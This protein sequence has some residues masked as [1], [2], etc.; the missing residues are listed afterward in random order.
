MENNISNSDINAY[1]MF[2]KVTV[3]P[4]SY[5]TIQSA[6]EAIEGFMVPGQEEYLFNKV[7][8]LP[9]DA[10]IVEIGSYKGRSTVAMSYACIGTNRKIY[11]LDTWD[12]NDTDFSD[13]NFFDIWQENIEKNGL[14]QYVVP[15]RGYSHQILSQW[16]EL[17]G[18]KAIDFIFI[19]GSHQFLDVLK[20][21]EQSLPLVKDG[22]WIAFHDVVPT[23][24]GPERVWHNIAKHCLLNHE[25][26]S[27]LACGQKNST[28]FSSTSSPELPIHFFTI[29]LNGEPFIEYHIEV[30]KQLPYK[31]HWHIVEGVAD[32]KHDTAWSLLHG[33]R[34]TDEIHS[35][36]RSNDGTAEYLDELAQLYPENVT[37]YRKPEGIFWEGKREMV[38]APLPNIRE[39]CLLWQ[40]DVDEL[41]TGEQLCTARYMF[42]NNPEKTAA[43]YW[44]WYFVGE[45][46]VISTRNCYAQNP[47]QEWL[48]TWRFKPGHV[49]VRHEPPILAEPLP[50]GDLRN[51][52]EFN[53]FRHE[54]TENLGLVF[55]H[56]AYVIPEQ[57]RFKEQYYGY[58]NALSQWTALQQQTKFPALLRQYLG[59]VQDGTTVDTAESCGVVPI[60]QKESNGTRWRFV[61]PDGLQS[62]T[63]TTQTQSPRILI[64][65]VFFQLY[66][67]G[68]ARV[69]NSL[70]EEWAKNGFSQHIIILDRA[71]TA[72]K[73]VGIRYLTIPAY[74]YGTADADRQMLQQVCDE[75]GADLFISTYYTTPLSTPSVFM[76]YDMIPEVLEANLNEPMWRVKHHGIR[77]ASAY[78]AISENTAQDLVKFFPNI[79]LGS[80]S[81]AHC[82]VKSSFSPASKE[83][84]SNFKNKYGISKP[85]FISVGGGSDYKNTEL[86]FQAFAQLSS[87]QGFEV[88]CTGSSVLLELEFRAYTAG[89]VVHKLNLNDEELRVAYSGAIALVYP[90]LYEGF[91]LPVLEAM[92]CG[93]PVITCPNAS[94]PEVAGEA[95]LYVNDKD[96]EGFAQALCEVQKPKVRN[97]L[98]RGGLE[99]AK[100]FS[101][102]KMAKIV[103]SVLMKT[104]I[105]I[106][107]E[108]GKESEGYNLQE[109]IKKLLVAMRDQPAYQL[110]LPSSLSQIPEPFLNE[111]IS[112]LFKNP[113][114][115]QEVGEVEKYYQH[116]QRWVDELHTNIVGQLDVE[117]WR[118]VAITFTYSANF[119]LYFT[120]ANLKEIYVK[121][122]T[123]I[124]QTLRSK[125]HQ[126]D[127]S[128]PEKLQDT[129]KIRLGILATNF[130]PQAEI[131][132]TLPVYKSLN[133]DLFEIIIYFV[134]ATG[135]RFERYCLGCAD[136]AV[137]LPQDLESQVQTIRDG[138]LDILF[139]ATNVTAQTNRIAE[140]A[141]HR[142]ARVQ[143]VGMN[144]PVSTGMRHVD[145]YISSKLTEAGSNPQQHYS[146]TLVTLD[147]PA[148]CF[149]FA[150]EEQLLTTINVNRE[151]LNIAQ[152]AVIYISGANFYKIIPEVEETWAK[153]LARVPNSVL[154]LYPFNPNW[155]PI[156]PVTAFEERILATLARHGVG[157]DRLILLDAV[158]NRADVKERLKVADIYLDSYPYA[159]MTSLIDPLE[160]GVPTVVMS[161]DYARSNMGA[162][163]LRELEMFDLIVDSEEAYVELAVALGTNPELRFQKSNLLNQKMQ[164][165]PRFLDSRSYSARIGLVF[166]EIFAKYQGNILKENLRLSALNLIIF[167]DWGQPEE[168]LLQELVSVLRAIAT[169]P[170]KS[171][172][173]LL[174]DSSNVSDDDANL[175]LSSVAMN[176]LMEEDLD[177]SEGPEISLVGQLSKLQWQALM[178]HL[179]GRIVL[180]QE[181]TE[182]STPTGFEKIPSY[183]LES[184]TN[185]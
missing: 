55:Q 101:W 21:Y 6:V 54:E 102:S 70:L 171:K 58:T 33:G 141:V 42:I 158:P 68:I 20:D 146:E 87:K 49:W 40:V 107:D 24:P 4:V 12:G 85:Y 170:D 84:I 43:F 167:P 124:E 177:V 99:Q 3:Q 25:Y 67:T 62:R 28:A 154:V 81:V 9:N 108:N 147:V 155:A 152:S 32:L 98:I 127:Y 129:S 35:K 111:Y 123:I 89:T 13:R 7:K 56:F 75:E 115:F 82:G 19:D 69:W 16:E 29:V 38:N 17:T 163:L 157:K 161:G 37:V 66:R 178:S 5:T 57:L 104:A 122:A 92:A 71:G 156:Y 2:K 11:C 168:L 172:M 134:N 110:S 135:H 46:L 50:N 151:I 15:L 41:W 128:F 182:V 77:H 175:I 120:K 130:H 121:R 113:P 83:E 22:G 140:L 93:C 36:G 1:G 14:S 91:G 144:S 52:A 23:W 185:M 165:T 72:P 162:S 116:I 80:V 79:A 142:L 114:L 180:K 183:L 97:S 95:A 47:A 96:V 184:F 48:R 88:I 86:F 31:W 117:V 169:H 18:D 106:T 145:Y 118:E 34:I 181:N 74:N 109:S 131:F 45:N 10:V 112:L 125:G 159:G 63:L 103:S 179:Q 174:V 78:I 160:V 30:F 173:T 59:W 61:E 132:A 73:I 136:T 133:R 44:C 166:Q 153:I 64:D 137:R 143:V 100:K 176:L 105:S 39:E 148:Q 164:N 26:S 65:G 90:S 150:T 138:D 8:S 51:V 126:L 119:V 94:I 27:T 139:I 76:A 60:A 53:A 149:D